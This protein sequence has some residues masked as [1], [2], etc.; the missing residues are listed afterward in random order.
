LNYFKI[1]QSN[2]CHE[3]FILSGEIIMKNIISKLL[4]LSV[5]TFA[6]PAFAGGIGWFNPNKVLK[7]SAAGK[8]VLQKQKQLKRR[9]ENKRKS[10]EKPLM[11]QRVKLEKE[12]KNLQAQLNVLNAKE[13]QKRMNAF[14]VKYQALQLK[15]QKFQQTLVKFQ[16]KMT[17][18]F[19]KVAEPFSKKLRAAAKSIAKS[20]GYDFIIAHDPD[21]PTILLYAKP[22]L[23]ITSKL[24]NKLN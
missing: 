6:Y 1:K 19:Q 20:K 15:F 4:I 2:G 16:K 8:K 24:V 10:L 12:Y 11:K 5:L 21:N 17:N 23:E 9:F 7:K 13:K 18:D 22:S 3:C 14:K